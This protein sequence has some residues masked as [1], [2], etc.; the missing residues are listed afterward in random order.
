MHWRSVRV[1]HHQVVPR[2]RTGRLLTS[3]P[4]SLA[5]QHRTQV[6]REHDCT[7]RTLR[8][9]QLV[10]EPV[11]GGMYGALNV[12][13]RQV[14]LEVAP[15]KREDLSSPHACSQC[16]RSGKGI[17]RPGDGLQQPVHERLVDDDRLRSTGARRLCSR[18]GLR[19][20]MSHRTAWPNAWVSTR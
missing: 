1:V 19:T 7:S 11:P 2:H 13:D 15:A 14:G 17:R 6:F 5:V 12:S 4:F 8:L 9:R 3:L 18:T 16:D 10:G 20:I